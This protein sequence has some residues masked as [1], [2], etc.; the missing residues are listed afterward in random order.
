MPIGEG[1]VVERGEGG[2]LPLRV[3][4]VLDGDGLETFAT[5]WAVVFVVGNEVH[6][7]LAATGSWCGASSPKSCGVKHLE[8]AGLHSSGGVA[9]GLADESTI[10]VCAVGQYDVEL[11]RETEQLVRRGTAE[12]WRAP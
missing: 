8:V 9:V 1:V 10:R 12:T 4:R 11:S 6:A 2:T 7:V 5:D 3:S